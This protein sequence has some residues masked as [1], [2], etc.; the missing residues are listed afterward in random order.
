MVL[1]LLVERIPLPQPLI[2]HIFWYVSSPTATLF[3]R[4]RYYHHPSPYR[5]LREVSHYPRL[6]PIAVRKEYYRIYR[7]TFIQFL[8]DAKL[9][10]NMDDPVYALPTDAEF[11]MEEEDVNVNQV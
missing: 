6:C 9:E 4:T 2:E 11:E 3:R 1:Q 10:V 8:L 7:D 5:K